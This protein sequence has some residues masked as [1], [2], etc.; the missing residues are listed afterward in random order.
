M[1]LEVEIILLLHHQVKKLNKIIKVVFWITIKIF[2]NYQ[3]ID[4]LKLEY[5]WLDKIKWGILK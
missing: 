1:I 2:K 4:R 3:N 5:S